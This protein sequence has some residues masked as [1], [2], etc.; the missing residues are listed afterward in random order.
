MEEEV[1]GE[2]GGLER[3]EEG[4]RVAE[5]SPSEASGKVLEGG[6]TSSS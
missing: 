3:A 2:A 5:T 1:A 4:T 6:R